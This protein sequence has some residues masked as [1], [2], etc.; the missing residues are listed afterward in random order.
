MFPPLFIVYT[1]F[2]LVFI[3]FYIYWKK[4]HTYYIRENSV[5]IT[6]DWVFGRYQREITF[7]KIQDVH[8][9]QG[10]LARMFKCGSVVF[11]TTTGLEVG[12]TVAGGGGYTFA[13]T[14]I[15][16]GIIGGGGYTYSGSVLPRLIRG[17][18]TLS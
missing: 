6:R 9:Q 3:V 14:K 2:A 1:I 18:G 16:P 5:L 11:V 17:P 10:L 12:Y 15:G 8:V 4:A 13:G 7:D